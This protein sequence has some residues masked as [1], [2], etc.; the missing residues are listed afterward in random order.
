MAT[1]PSLLVLVAALLLALISPVVVLA[2]GREQRLR[3]RV[4][5]H[6][7]F[8]GPSPLDGPD[9]SSQEV[10]RY[11]GLF[12]GA[13]LPDANARVHRSTAGA[14]CR[15]YGFLGDE[16]LEGGTVRRTMVGD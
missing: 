10:G 12:A 15:S 1:S 2:S 16:V 5:V 11:H 4:Y 14:R 13:D 7:Q 6:E 8:W 9:P 3:I